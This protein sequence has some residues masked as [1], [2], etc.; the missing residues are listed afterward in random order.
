MEC[1]RQF[2]VEHYE[3]AYLPE[4][5]REVLSRFDDKAIHLQLSYELIYD[6]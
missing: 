6:V 3:I 5:A 2:A 4:K 1:A